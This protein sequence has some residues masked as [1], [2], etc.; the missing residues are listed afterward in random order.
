[1]IWGL[2]VGECRLV[3]IYQ[4]VEGVYSSIKY[5]QEGIAVCSIHKRVYSICKREYVV[6][7]RGLREYVPVL[8]VLLEIEVE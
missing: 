2:G 7:T 4:R 1:M 5:I 3:R 8:G 6:Y